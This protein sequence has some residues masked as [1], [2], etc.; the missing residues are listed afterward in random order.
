[1]ERARAVRALSGA[2]LYPENGSLIFDNYPPLSFYLVG[3]LGH[4]FHDN[5]FAGRIVSWLSL[6]WIVYNIGSIIL[7]QRVE[8]KFAVYGA[9]VFI[10]LITANGSQFIGVDDPQLLGHAFQTYGLSVLLREKPQ[11]LDRNIIFCFSCWRAPW[12]STT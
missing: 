1:M 4:L 11:A 6:G 5:V 9:L 2:G 10:L 12:S 3:A 7:N 8:A